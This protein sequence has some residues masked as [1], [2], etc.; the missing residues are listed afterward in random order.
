MKHAFSTVTFKRS[1]LALCL[2]APWVAPSLSAQS[3]PV[4]SELR[5]Q[6]G[7]NGFSIF[8]PLNPSL[9][10]GATEVGDVDGDGIPDAMVGAP[11]DDGGL[12]LVYLLFLNADGTVR[13]QKEIGEGKGG[14]GGSL[15][16][17]GFGTDI[18]FLGDVDGDGIGDVAVGHPQFS[19][20]SGAVWILFL[21]ATGEVASEQRISSSS[22]GLGV[23]L[24]VADFFGT[25]VEAVVDLNGDGVPDVAVGAWGDDDDG[26]DKGAVYL[27]QLQANGTVLST[28][29]I[30]QLAGLFTGSLFVNGRFGE[31]LAFLGD[32]SG[33]GAPELAVGEPGAGFAGG[34]RGRVWIL[35][36]SFGLVASNTAISY[37]ASFGGDFDAR[38]A[39]SLSPLGD[40][41][42]DGAVD[43]AVGA[44]KEGENGSIGDEGRVYVLY[45]DATGGLVATQ[46]IG[47]GLGGLQHALAANAEF[48]SSIA[49][50]GDLSGDGSLEVIVGE[51][52]RNAFHVLSLSTCAPV[53]TVSMRNAG[54]NPAS[55]TATRAILGQTW[56]VGIDLTTTGHDFG[57]VFG[58]TNPFQFTLG[59]GQVLLAIDGTNSGDLLGLA[60]Q[61]G[62]QVQY[63]V[64]VPS[65]PAYCGLEV[66][67]QAIHFGGITPFALS[68]AQDLVLGVE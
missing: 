25:A 38:F 45:L 56:D 35:S 10:L 15:S 39:M 34:Y 54:A 3:G 1:F 37:D 13:E 51:E 8:D 30:S 7:M 6:D 44:P 28:Q 50:L 33:D 43:L 66:Y 60:I 27:L 68:N 67:T 46:T 52:G 61:P 49:A 41:D 64:P 63:A 19:G 11:T 26:N 36:L 55:Y 14:F 31:A 32:L 40:L 18:A 47:K 20:L 9:G 21:D 42:G 62:P 22:G 24:D 12:G 29:K 48:G 4:V 23:S 5:I 58:F 53:A 59:S 2:V 16:T 17:G 65:S 57:V